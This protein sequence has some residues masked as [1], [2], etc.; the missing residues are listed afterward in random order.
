MPGRDGCFQMIQYCKKTQLC[1]AQRL[2]RGP[3]RR[4]NEE[5]LAHNTSTC[6]AL[7]ISNRGQARIS[8]M[9][10]HL[11]HSGVL[12]FGGLLLLGLSTSFAVAGCRDGAR[13]GVDWT[14]CSKGN[15]MLGK[16]NLAGA[17]LTSTRLTSTDLSGSNLSGAKLQGAELS[18]VRFEGADLSGADLTR[19]TGGRTSFARANL[20][21]ARFDSS[22]FSRSN[23]SGAQLL[24]ASL[25][26]SEMNRSSFQEADLTGADMSKA[27]LA[28]VVLTKAQVTRVNF[29]YSNLAR[30]DLRGLSLEG[31]DLAGAYLFLTRI[32]GADMSKAAGLKQEQIDLAC[33]TAE[34]RLPPGLAQPRDWPCSDEAEQ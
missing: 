25:T 20:R 18:F 9:Q 6:S 11:L 22:E 3:V 19:A 5:A 26:K 8:H 32:D 7:E 33:G 16:S 21:R 10:Q 30:A 17:V 27:E 13:A 23:F 28:R 14:D 2:G 31:A 29:S 24:E 15:L 4:D 12:S 34:T 1:H